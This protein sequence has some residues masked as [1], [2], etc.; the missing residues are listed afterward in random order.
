MPQRLRE[1]RRAVRLGP[2]AAC[3]SC[4]AEQCHGPRRAGLHPVPAAGSA[5]RSPALTQRRYPSQSQ[6]AH[7][8]A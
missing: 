2:D 6:R 7:G 3:A 8:L 1:A 4:R 5:R